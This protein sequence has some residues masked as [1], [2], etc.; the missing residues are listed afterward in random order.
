MSQRQKRPAVPTCSCLLILP[1]RPQA[2]SPFSF[3]LSHSFSLPFSLVSLTL[4]SQSLYLFL[5][6]L[7]IF[8]A[9]R[10]L[11]CT[12]LFFSHNTFVSLSLS[13]SISLSFQ[14]SALSHR[15]LIVLLTLSVSLHPFHN[16]SNP[17]SCL[18][19]SDSHF[20]FSIIPSELLSYR[21]YEAFP[22]FVKL[23]ASRHPIILS[24]GSK[25]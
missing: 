11:F 2:I 15:S 20:K 22:L 23:S 24:V 13:Y 8:S 6:I 4:L 19:L 16:Y 14:V 5:S 3:L 7:H 25:L 18:L 1:Y 21:S 10:D 9:F 12:T 17:D